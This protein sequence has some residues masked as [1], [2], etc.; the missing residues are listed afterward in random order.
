MRIWFEWLWSELRLVFRPNAIKHEKACLKAS[1][2]NLALDIAGSEP[3]EL[4]T[5]DL[6]PRSLR[7]KIKSN[8]LPVFIDPTSVLVRQL[9]PLKFPRSLV[10]RM[11]ELDVQAAVRRQGFWERLQLK[12]SEILAHH[13]VDIRQLD[14]GIANAAV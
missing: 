6:I 14:C 3:L 9:A 7:R 11:S 8:R 4:T 12:L 13:F 1:V 2:A 5:A 10:K